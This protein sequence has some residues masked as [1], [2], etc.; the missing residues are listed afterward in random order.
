MYHKTYI[1]CI[2]IVILFIIYN[3]SQDY[4]LSKYTNTFSTGGNGEAKG[5]MDLNPW[6]TCSVI[7]YSMNPI[8]ETNNWLL[9]FFD[10]MPKSKIGNE[11]MG[12]GP[13]LS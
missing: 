13:N 2:C 7:I 10:V 11:K 3:S 9:Y 1:V 12:H 8:Q 6:T 4:R 5:V